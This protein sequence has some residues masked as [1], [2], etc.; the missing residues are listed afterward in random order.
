M[1]ESLDELLW[2]SRIL[3]EQAQEKAEWKMMAERQ[4]D[5]QLSRVKA[6]LDRQLK[7]NDALKKHCEQLDNEI[8][9]LETLYYEHT[10][11]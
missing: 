6:S 4:L 3:E 1:S 9:C 7:T 10:E 11:Q 2:K 5:S 8:H